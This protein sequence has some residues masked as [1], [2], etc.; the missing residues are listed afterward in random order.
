[1]LQQDAMTLYINNILEQLVRILN[2]L[3]LNIKDFV[4]K[5]NSYKE[6]QE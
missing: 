6:H 4:G 3:Q 2:M 5:F 1:M